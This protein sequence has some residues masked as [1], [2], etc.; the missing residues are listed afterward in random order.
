LNLTR[1][2]NKSHVFASRQSFTKSAVLHKNH[3]LAPVQALFAA[4]IALSIV[5]E[6]A[7]G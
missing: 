4:R 2:L 3:V 6:T 7:E 5:A 1:G